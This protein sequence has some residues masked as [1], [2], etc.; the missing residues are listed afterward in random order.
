MKQEDII[1]KPVITEKSM[2]DAKAGKFTFA[3]LKTANKSA[4]K[5]ATEK[6]FNVHVVSLTT[7]IVKGTRKRTGKRMIEISTAFWKKATLRLK[8]DENIGLF[9]IGK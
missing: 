1:I 3:V 7:S 2:Q 4:I 6:K 9:D 8:K 5:L